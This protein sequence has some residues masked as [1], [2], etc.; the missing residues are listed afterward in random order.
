MKKKE[1]EEREARKQKRKARDTRND[2][3]AKSLHKIAR[4]F[5]KRR[6]FIIDY[7]FNGRK[8]TLEIAWRKRNKPKYLAQYT[9]QT[10][11]RPAKTKGTGHT[12]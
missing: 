10:P 9:A 12:E 7:A 4:D 6:Q 2:E 3:V 11:N 5:E 1:R 8:R